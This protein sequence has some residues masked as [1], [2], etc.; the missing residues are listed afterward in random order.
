MWIFK[1]RKKSHVN[2][3]LCIGC[4]TCI[5]N[6]PA[7]AREFNERGRAEINKDKCVG[8]NLCTNICRAKAINIQYFDKITKSFLEKD[9]IKTRKDALANIDKKSVKRISDENQKLQSMYKSYLGDPG[10]I[11]AIGLLH[12]DYLDKSDKLKNVYIKKRKK[13]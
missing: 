1:N 4:G 12:T 7:S 3:S 8:C 5:E 13:H 10:S 2:E 9:Y 6:C 11:R